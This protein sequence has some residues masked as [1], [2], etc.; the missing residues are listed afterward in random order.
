[1]T[2]AL[3]P[4]RSHIEILGEKAMLYKGRRDLEE[5]FLSFNRQTQFEKN[6]DAYSND[7]SPKVIMQRFA[8]VFIK[9]DFDPRAINSLDK[10]MIEG[11]RFKRK[12]RNLSKK[13]YL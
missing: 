3:S 8:D 5:M 11:Y 10:L 4:Q 2:Y 7:F 9:G 1:M 6:W 13:L 12:L